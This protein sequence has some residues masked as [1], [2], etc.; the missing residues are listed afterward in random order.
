MEIRKEADVQG[1]TSVK[2]WDCSI[3][4]YDQKFIQ[5]G[6]SAVEGQYLYTTF[7]PF[8]EASTTR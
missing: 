5:E 8:A 1:L 3:Q 2:V 4:C 6:G 7:V